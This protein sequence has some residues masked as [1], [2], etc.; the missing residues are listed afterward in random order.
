MTKRKRDSMESDIEGLNEDP[1]LPNE[2]A[3]G[4]RKKDYYST[5]YVDA[6]YSSVSQR[7]IAEAELEEQEAR[8]LQKRLAEQLD[9]ADFG[10]DLIIAHQDDV[11]DEKEGERVKTDLSKFSKRQKQELLEKES[12]EFM[13]LVS[14][15]Q[16]RLDEAASTLRPFLD[17][18]AKNNN[19]DYPSIEFIKTKYDL[20]LHYCT[21]ISFYLMLKAN[22]EP[23]ASHP[24]I[25]RL[26]QYRKLL[27][28]FEEYQS[29]IL[30]RIQKILQ[31][32][33]DGQPLF[34]TRNSSELMCEKKLEHLET[35]I[36]G[37]KGSLV[38]SKS[39]PESTENLDLD[40]NDMVLRLSD[41]SDVENVEKHEDDG[42]EEK[43]AITYQIAKNKG[44]TPHRKKEQ[45]NPRVKHRLKYRKAIIR[46]KG[47][48][49]TVRKET[50]R[51]SGE[52][53][54]IKASVSKSIKLK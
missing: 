40:G 20:I 6:D 43:R 51:Y 53:S 31:A 5:D 48:V 36:K 17:L 1:D 24:V 45:R 19:P 44:L 29:D 26:A 27:L 47:A 12:P 38:K 37:K 16:E 2:K 30:E 54:G 49:R 33:R 32:D 13:L 3:W 46:R 42:S 28:Q 41:G 39:E 14:D 4:K 8:N 10:L 22:R 18:V 11:E 25:K 15:F 23:V 35:S 9:E 34:S 7:E 50:S 21:N 52:L